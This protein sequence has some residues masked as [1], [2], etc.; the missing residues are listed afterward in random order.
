MAD[1]SS[2]FNRQWPLLQQADLYAP[3]ENPTFRN[4]SFDGAGFRVLVMR[5][6]P[7]SD[8][9]RSTPHLFLFDAVR[10]AAPEAYVD[11]AFFPPRHDRERLES[12]GV[13]LLAG[14]QS[15]RSIEDFDLVL[16]SNAYTL[17]LVNLPYLLIHSGVPPLASR[18]GEEWPPLILG[19]SN[20]LASQ[21]IVAEDGDSLVD[22][23]F[24]GEGEGQVR[25]LVRALCQQAGEP[26]RGRLEH[27]A[28]ET[29]GLWI[30][31]RWPEAPVEKAVLPD[32]EGTH[33]PINYPL[34]NSPEAGTARL[35][36]TYGCPAFCSFCFEG[37]DRKPY[38]EVSRS[39][40]LQVARQLKWIQGC[41]TFSLY[42]FNF[43]THREILPLLLDLNRLFDRV[44]FTSQRVDLLQNTPGLLE[45]EVAA[46][47]RSFTLG[48]EGISARLRA[49]LH[50]SLATEEIVGLLDRL[51]R[52]KIRSIKLFYILT[53]H[54]DEADLAEFHAFV[55]HLRALRRRHNPGIRITFSCG[56]LVRMPFTPLRYDRLFLTPSPRCWPWPGT[57]SS[58]PSSTWPR[59]AIVTRRLSPPAIGT[60]SGRGWMRKDAGRRPFWARR[61]RSTSSLSTSSSRTSPPTSSTASSSRRRPAS[62]RGTA[63]AAT[64]RL[65]AAWGAVPAGTRPSDRRSWRTRSSRR[66]TRPTF[67][68]CG[69]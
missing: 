50:K 66:M 7:F 43:N 9:D 4:P 47:K 61:G 23:I 54:E 10:R 3:R 36:I 42:S 65:G 30:T 24:F 40:V 52:E 57:A 34:L 67:R 28:R 18:R 45:A 17:E 25:D 2:F 8:V 21:A 58:S 13:P 46:D 39:D 41:D 15:A 11:L 38:R 53:G 12:A 44:R 37:Y 68:T 64:T 35:Q 26:K 16:I 49:W 55:K 5:L 63:W 62:T 60:R 19:G 31:G 51:L 6:S 22:A 59:R 14:I 69:A 27:A 20:A 33:L 48:V 29:T 1:Y 56:L 32:P